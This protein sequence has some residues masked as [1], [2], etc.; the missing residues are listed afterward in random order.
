MIGQYFDTIIVASSDKE[1]LQRPIKNYW[2]I[3]TIQHVNVMVNVISFS[4]FCTTS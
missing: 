4:A 3:L 1:W 2:N